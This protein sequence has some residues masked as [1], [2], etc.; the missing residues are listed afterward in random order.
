ME[1]FR[2]S[3]LDLEDKLNKACDRVIRAFRV[4]SDVTDRQREQL[5][6]I[7]LYRRLYDGCK[8]CTAKYSPTDWNRGGSREFRVDKHALFYQDSKFGWA[9]KEIKFCPMC[10]RP[11]TEEAWAEL[12]RRINLES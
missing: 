2:K 7:R 6:W 9:G 5:E 10:G 12:E 3:I 8:M 11:L 1:E 4:Q